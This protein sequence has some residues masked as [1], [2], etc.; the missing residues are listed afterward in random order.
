M[1]V[2]V[3]KA[4]IEFGNEHLKIYRRSSYGKIIIIGLIFLTATIA[5]LAQFVDFGEKEHIAQ[6]LLQ[7]DIGNGSDTGSGY[8][9]GDHIISAIN[10]SKAS[11][12]VIEADSNGGS[13][14]DSQIIDG[15]ITQYKEIAKLD[16]EVLQR[17][18][19]EL[20]STNRIFSNDVLRKAEVNHVV[21]QGDFQELIKELPRKLIIAVISKS[22]ASACVQA[23]VNADII[24][25]QPAS[26]VGNIGVRMDSYNW[27]DLAKKLGITNTVIT[28][29]PHK[30]MLSPWQHSSSEQQGLARDML[31]IPVFEQFKRSVLTARKNKLNADEKVLFSGLIWTGQ[32]AKRIG[33]VDIN[34]DKL[35]TRKNLESMSGL[36]YL[37]YSK[38]EYGLSKIL[39]S[40]LN[41]LSYQ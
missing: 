9:V 18:S 24:I 29:G 34:S 13:P 26:L 38:T 6:I 30:D 36:E 19:D 17:I 35:Q 15:V 4:I 16:V 40:T 33:L 37:S 22:C 3:E 25:A 11:A 8:S 31:V 5:N 32:E 21:V 41:W 20:H 28:S 7:G 23:I 39:S 10:N 2:K 14:T 12:I 1:D 27:H